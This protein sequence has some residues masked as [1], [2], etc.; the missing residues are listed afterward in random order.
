MGVAPSEPN[1]RFSKAERLLKRS[2]FMRLSARGNR[3]QNRH[4][5]CLFD[6]NACSHPRLGVTVS[7]RIGKATVRNRIKRLC[8]EH[9]RTRR[10]AIGIHVDL[11]IIAK[12]GVAELTT[13]QVFRSLDDIIDR[14]SKWHFQ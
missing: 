11:N 10:D 2:E 3:T 6:I 9:F 14:I 13:A 12:R 1:N 5:I 4:F 8:R 7:K